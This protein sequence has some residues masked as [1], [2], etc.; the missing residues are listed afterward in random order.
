MV[1]ALKSLIVAD[2]SGN[3]F[4]SMSPNKKMKAAILSAEAMKSANIDGAKNLSAGA[5]ADSKFMEHM[6]AMSFKRASGKSDK[7]VRT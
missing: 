3:D 5:A 4:P 7:S 2:I 6:M 1:S